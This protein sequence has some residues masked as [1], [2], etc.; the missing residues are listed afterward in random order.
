MG[1]TSVDKAL[2]N[3]G[4]SINL[5]PYS[6]FKK[7]GLADPRPTRMSLQLVDH[8]V[9]IP[10]G[11]IEYVLVKVDNFIYLVDFVILDMDED[12][13]VP[14]ILGRP[15]L[16]TARAVIDVEESKLTLR[17]GDEELVIKMAAAMKHSMCVDDSCYSIDIID[18]SVNAH[19]DEVLC[20][21]GLEL[22]L[23]WGEE[24]YTDNPEFT[25]LIE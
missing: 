21:D 13:D 10:K 6:F 23:T 16:A 25:V 1:D 3:L 9:K 19:M 12:E 2:L 7:L 8:S 20:K 4:V 24:R 11:I 15:F 22:S 18:H 5:M 14:L 17:I